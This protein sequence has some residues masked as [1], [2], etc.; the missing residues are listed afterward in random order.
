MIHQMV[1]NGH[2]VAPPMRTQLTDISTAYF[3]QHEIDYRRDIDQTTV[4]GNSP[5]A[6]IKANPIDDVVAVEWGTSIASLSA[7]RIVG[8]VTQ[9][10][11]YGI[12]NTYVVTQ[13]DMYGIDNT[14]V[15]TAASLQYLETDIIPRVLK[16]WKAS[17]L[18]AFLNMESGQS[19]VYENTISMAHDTLVWQTS[20]R[21][22]DTCVK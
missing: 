16:K 14:Y 6:Y 8:V 17:D 5:C 3:K 7:S 20:S 18:F 21:E 10:D 4:H 22:Q 12:D 11:V 19:L 1:R 2:A 15:A 13:G 9:G